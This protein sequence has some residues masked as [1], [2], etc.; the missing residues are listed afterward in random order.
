MP[1]GFHPRKRRSGRD[2]SKA[3]PESGV[4]SGSLRAKLDRRR[5]TFPQ[6]PFFFGQLPFCESPRSSGRYGVANDSDSTNLASTHRSTC[7]IPVIVV[8]DQQVHGVEPPHL[9]V[10]RLVVLEIPS[11]RPA[12]RHSGPRNPT[13]TDTDGC[14]VIPQSSL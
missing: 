10:P 4:A 3:F 11:R 13:P 12:I 8:T 5:S 9:R 14:I 6:R 2:D 1:D 7:A